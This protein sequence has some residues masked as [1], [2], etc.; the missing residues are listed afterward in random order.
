MKM[1][2]HS[3]NLTVSS[4][5]GVDRLT[6]RFVTTDFDGHILNIRTVFVF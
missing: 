4:K 1:Y 6:S 2:L 3:L 5:I